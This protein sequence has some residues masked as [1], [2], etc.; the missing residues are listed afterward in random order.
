MFGFY[1]RSSWK[2]SWEKKVVLYAVVTHLNNDS[3]RLS[4]E[5]EKIIFYCNR[6]YMVKLEFDEKGLLNQKHK[7][8]NGF[9]L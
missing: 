2:I 3:R 1:F 4:T 8:L 5:E 9:E 6:P 7:T